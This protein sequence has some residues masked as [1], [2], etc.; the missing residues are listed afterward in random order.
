MTVRVDACASSTTSVRALLSSVCCV[1]VFP[2]AGCCC[3]GVSA[4]WARKHTVLR[5]VILQPFKIQWSHRTGLIVSWVI[6]CAPSHV[7]HRECWQHTTSLSH[8][9]RWKHLIILMTDQ[10]Q[11]MMLSSY[12]NLCSRFLKLFAHFRTSWAHFQH[13]QFNPNANQV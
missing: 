4:G 11:C 2:A 8:T 1:C 12:G 9:C 6:F 13:W 7:C 5:V 10:R 3:R